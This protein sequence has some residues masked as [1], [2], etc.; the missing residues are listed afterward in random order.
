[1]SIFIHKL[2]VLTSFCFAAVALGAGCAADSAGEEDSISDEIA[3]GRA[4]PTLQISPNPVQA[5]SL[6]V[7]KPVVIGSGFAAGRSY[8]LQL[9]GG[10]DSGALD[11][12]SGTVI[13]D[14]NGKFTWPLASEV[15]DKI[16]SG[17]TSTLTA[18]YCKSSRSCSTIASATLTITPNPGSAAITP[19]AAPSGTALSF[20]GSGA[21][22]G[23]SLNA[24]W[25]DMSGCTCSW[26]MC[27]GCTWTQRSISLNADANGAFSGTFTPAVISSGFCAHT[28][29]IQD[30]AS[31]A[32]VATTQFSFCP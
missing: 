17:P 25:D 16:L 2:G 26:F 3:A 4:A 18:T 12:I 19:F 6:T 15:A 8:N 27:T 14:A 9:N 24:L 13:A 31:S 21:S 5:G 32:I 22:P 11:T 30:S 29:T 28:F 10:Y 7:T 20:S 23:A 1:M